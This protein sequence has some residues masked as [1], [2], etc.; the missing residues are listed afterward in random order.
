M[1]IPVQKFMLDMMLEVVDMLPQ[2]D[3]K[4]TLAQTIITKKEQFS[5]V[6]TVFQ[7]VCSHSFQ[8]E[9]M[10]FFFNGWKATHLKMLPIYGLSCRLNVL[11]MDS[12]SKEEKTAFLE[13]SAYN[14]STSHED[15][16]I[17]FDAV[18]HG[19][20]YDDFAYSLLQS[21]EWKLAKYATK[22][23]DTFSEWIYK[24]MLLKPIP[25]ALCI[26]MIS[27]FYNHAEYAY[28]YHT[29]KYAMKQ[30]YG[31][32]DKGIEKAILYIDVHNEHETEIHHFLAV[33][34]SIRKYEEASK[35]KVSMEVL[36][37]VINTY[38]EMICTALQ[39]I[40][41]NFD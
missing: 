34:N 2:S 36:Q 32:D 7:N 39:A 26:N 5:R 14:A 1:G 20:L 4:E 6:E 29:F 30:F 24:G 15:L 12:Q 11:G 8:K 3:I 17:G 10:A 13:A 37:E 31:M 18:S 41:K 23:A 22:E 27:E 21:D 40:E 19:K 35:E 28:S 9:K 16:G 38:A 25:Y 33:I